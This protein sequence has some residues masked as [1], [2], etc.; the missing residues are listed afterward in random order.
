MSQCTPLTTDRPWHLG[1]KMTFV[2]PALSCISLPS[3]ITDPS[4]SSL[5]QRMQE[6]QFYYVA[7]PLQSLFVELLHNLSSSQKPSYGL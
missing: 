4:A 7:L 3:E 5:P 2:T 1:H 6:V